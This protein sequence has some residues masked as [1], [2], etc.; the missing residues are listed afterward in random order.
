MQRPAH[1]SP[2]AAPET[3]KGRKPKKRGKEHSGLGVVVHQQQEAFPA[4][5]SAEMYST[6]H[7]LQE[8][9]ENN[10]CYLCND[11]D[12]PHVARHHNT[13]K[14]LPEL[15]LRYNTSGENWMMIKGPVQRGMPEKDAG[16]KQFLAQRLSITDISA[17]LH[18]HGRPFVTALLNAACGL[19][20][21]PTLRSQQAGAGLANIPV[22]PQIVSTSSQSCPFQFTNPAAPFVFGG[23]DPSHEA[24]TG[25]PP[26]TTPPPPGSKSRLKKKNGKK[27][28]QTGEFVEGQVAAPARTV[29]CATAAASSSLP[30]ATLPPSSRTEGPF[31]ASPMF[32]VGQ[33]LT[34]QQM[35]VQ[36]RLQLQESIT[37]LQQ[38]QM[39]LEKSVTS[40]QVES[41]VSTY[42][43][44]LQ[45]LNQ[46]WSEA[47]IEEKIQAKR[48]KQMASMTRG[49][50][51]RAIATAGGTSA[52]PLLLTEQTSGSLAK[53]DGSTRDESGPADDALNV[54]MD[55]DKECG[56]QDL[57]TLAETVDASDDGAEP[58]IGKEQE[59]EPRPCPEDSWVQGRKSFGSMR[60][61]DMMG[62]MHNR[63]L[64]Q[65]SAVVMPPFSR[66]VDAI[67]YLSHVC[68]DGLFA[69]TKAL[70]AKEEESEFSI[71]K[72]RSLG[73]ST[74]GD[75]F[76]LY[77]EDSLRSQTL[78]TKAP[79]AP[80]IPEGT[81]VWQLPDHM[82]FIKIWRMQSLKSLPLFLLIRDR[83]PSDATFL[84]RRRYH[85]DELGG[86][87]NRA[88]CSPAPPARTPDC[89]NRGRVHGHETPN[90]SVTAYSAPFRFDVS[91]SF[92]LPCARCEHAG[93]NSIVAP[94]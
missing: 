81:V 91:S 27:R 93:S 53:S 57:R 4:E 51:P 30:V 36:W 3:K 47:Q 25:Q 63:L 2:A 38:G 46:G 10:P 90:F 72:V 48:E 50:E 37:T 74:Q 61:S 40:L 85:Q 18:M 44:S 77:Q 43:V 42:M 87:V 71:R 32:N 35:D 73:V 39:N 33:R 83:N 76:L 23:Q 88:A 17:F 79:Q 78:D 69:I 60:I 94:A 6:G 22:A 34:S 24:R 13:K 59:R 9:C 75:K 52:T 14:W 62:E 84:T 49:R 19:A 1:L 67:H 12:F 26:T 45:L 7:S 92:L 86:C 5:P 68:K 41:S 16:Q 21:F 66:R 8:H 64:A 11:F 82:L 70:G 56:S 15:T 54:D 28:T 29:P 55:A 58:D 65:E 89:T 80:V 31:Y 20:P